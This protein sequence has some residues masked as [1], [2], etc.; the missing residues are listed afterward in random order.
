[1]CRKTSCL[2]VAALLLLAPPLLAGGPAWV[3]VP[4]DGVTAENAKAASEELTAKLKSFF[5]RVEGQRW[6]IQF[7]HYRDQTYLVFRIGSEVGLSDIEKA[8]KGTSFSVP[9]EKLHLFGDAILEIDTSTRWP[10]KLLADLDKRFTYA[11]L[12]KVDATDG[13]FLVTINMP[14]PTDTSLR[15]ESVRW[16]SFHFHDFAADRSKRSLPAARPEMLLGYEALSDLVSEHGA[17]LK[18]IRWSPI[19]G[20]RPLGGVAAAATGDVVSA[21][22]TPA[23][24]NNE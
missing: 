4:I 22:L 19:Y 24:A 17:T 15:E 9:R 7:P 14:Y 21:R 6:G 10:M 23:V 8:L 1:M 13:Q 18:D 12:A 11:S 5:P 20:C 2:A 16:S 3:S